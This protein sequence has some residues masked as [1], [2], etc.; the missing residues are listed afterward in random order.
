MNTIVST[1]QPTSELQTS[2]VADH[3]PALV[4][5]LT[6]LDLRLGRG[7]GRD[8]QVGDLIASADGLTV[9]L[10]SVATADEIAQL[11][12]TTWATARRLMNW[13]EP[14]TMALGTLLEIEALAAAPELAVAL[15]NRFAAALRAAL[16]PVD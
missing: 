5:L 10:Q 14:S 13:Q 6:T 2:H 3:L 9:A 1:D 8:V 7:P 15:L 16:L 12:P 4:A 11:N